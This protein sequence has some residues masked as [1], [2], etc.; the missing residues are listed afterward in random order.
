MCQS[1]CG[2]ASLWGDWN[3]II[4]SY[5]SDNSVWGI[6]HHDG[7]GYVADILE[8]YAAPILR[9][10]MMMREVLFWLLRQAA[11]SYEIS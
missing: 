8:E 10:E 7:N 2:A 5:V 11:Q 4:S 6:L 1:L 3:F 9:V